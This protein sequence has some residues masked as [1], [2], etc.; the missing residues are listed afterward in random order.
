MKPLEKTMKIA[1]QERNSEKAALQQLLDNYRDTSHPSTGISPAAMMVRES[2]KAF[3]QDL[4][5]TM[6]KYCLQRSK[7]N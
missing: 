1:Q 7:M 2:S 6:N 5:S 4:K 3:F